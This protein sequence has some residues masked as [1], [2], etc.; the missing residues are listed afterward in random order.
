MAG[1]AHFFSV[2]VSWIAIPCLAIIGILFHRKR[3][4]KESLIFASGIVLTA[5]GSLIQIFFPFGKITMDEA[6]GILSSSGAPLGW[7]TGSIITSIGLIITV[8]GF[9]LVTWKIRK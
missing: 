6:R 8:L 7:Y 1:F 9:A 2:Y 5:C 4:T 3:K